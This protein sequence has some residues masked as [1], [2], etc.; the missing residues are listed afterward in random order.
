MFLKVTGLREAVEADMALVGLTTVMEPE[1]IEDIAAFFEGPIATS[2]HAN[3]H[4]LVF[5]MSRVVNAF[6]FI[7]LWRNALERFQPLS[8]VGGLLWFA[9]R[10]RDGLRC[11]LRGYGDHLLRLGRLNFLFLDIVFL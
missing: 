5:V 6:N 3:I 1:M 11:I 7:P 4:G 10:A 2:H 9:Q 8:C